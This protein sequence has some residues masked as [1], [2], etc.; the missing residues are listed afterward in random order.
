MEKSEEK[1]TN[2]S[3]ESARNIACFFVLGV[4][5]LIFDEI[6]LAAAEDVLAGSVIPT[7]IVIISIAVPVLGVKTTAP[8]FLQKCSYSH[9]SFVVVILLVTGLIVIVSVQNV[10][11]RLFGISVI[12]SGVSFSEITFLA[13]TASYQEVTVS[14]FVAGIGVS[15]LLGPLY[16]TG[17]LRRLILGKDRFIKWAASLNNKRSLLGQP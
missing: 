6:S 13:L 5:S 2:Y 16:Y 3:R 15:S 7:T 1:T 8:W 10:H 9:K 4:L 17:E 12:E 14:A 11:W